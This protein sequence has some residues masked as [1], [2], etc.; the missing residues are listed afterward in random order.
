[1]L[2][3]NDIKKLAKEFATKIDLE[4]VKIDLQSQIERMKEEMVTK[5]DHRKVMGLVE[6]VYTEV[7]KIREEQSMHIG[8]HQR[9]DEA[10]TEVKERISKLEKPIV[11]T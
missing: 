11:A 2:T 10:M 4:I 6:S 5:N 7:K 3:D 1:M 8:I 9:Q